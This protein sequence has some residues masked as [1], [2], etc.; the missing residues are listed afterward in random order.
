MPRGNKCQDSLDRGLDV[1]PIL[2]ILDRTPEYTYGTL[3]TKT[4]NWP[5]FVWT[6]FRNFRPDS[7]SELKILKIRLDGWTGIVLAL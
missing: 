6:L 3:I 4:P 2:T 5:F 7:G 1:P